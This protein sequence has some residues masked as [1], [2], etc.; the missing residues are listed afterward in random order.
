[1]TNQP[2]LP[3]RP[4]LGRVLTFGLLAA[5]AAAVVVAVAAFALKQIF[6]IEDSFQPL[7]PPSAAFLTVVYTLIGTG[8]LAVVTRLATNPR[9]TFLR[10]ATLGLAFSFVPQTVLL[11]TGIEVPLGEFTLKNVLVL[12]S[13]H[14]V[15]AAVALPILLRV[16][17]P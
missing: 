7:T 12:S 6:Q 3:F 17:R 2:D 10:L 13:L 5:G 1:M 9:R 4:G 11:V 15:A 8:V 16:F 14:L